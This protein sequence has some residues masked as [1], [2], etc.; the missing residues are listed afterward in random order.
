MT[1]TI[2]SEGLRKYQTR[3]VPLLKK[4]HLKAHCGYLKKED[5]YFY[6]ILWSDEIK[7]QLYDNNCTKK[8]W[9]ESGSMYNKSNTLLTSKHD[10]G[11][12]VWGC[13]SSSGT[14]KLHV[15]KRKKKSQKYFDILDKCPCSS[16]RI[17][18]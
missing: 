18:G 5:S 14:G 1:N 4:G 12:M 6:K 16:A 15:I 2:K 3:E 7:V 17:I 9:H 10:G 11:R 8:V 13:F